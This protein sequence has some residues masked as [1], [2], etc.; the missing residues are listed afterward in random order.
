M[1]SLSAGK[2]RRKPVQP[3]LHGKPDRKDD[4]GLVITERVHGQP[5]DYSGVGSRW[6]ICPA[7]R[8][9]PPASRVIRMVTSRALGL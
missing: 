3:G 2:L 1:W 6:V 5:S 9:V 8:T 4:K 7:G